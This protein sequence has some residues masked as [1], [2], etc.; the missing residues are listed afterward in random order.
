MDEAV[1]KNVEKMVDVGDLIAH[2]LASQFD[3]AQRQNPIPTL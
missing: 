2:C 3:H 1:S